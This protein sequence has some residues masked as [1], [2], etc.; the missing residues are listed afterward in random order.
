MHF[1]TLYPI[2]ELTTG[3]IHILDSFRVTAIVTTCG[4]MCWSNLHD[5][6][7]WS[8]ICWRTFMGVTLPC[9]VKVYLWVGL[10]DMWGQCRGLSECIAMIFCWVRMHGNH[11]C[12][13][14]CVCV[15]MCVCVCVCVCVCMSDACAHVFTFSF[16]VYIKQYRN[17]QNHSHLT[18]DIKFGEGL[19]Y[20]PGIVNMCWPD[21]GCNIWRGYVDLGS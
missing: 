10:A 19:L 11:V 6:V 9:T 5:I 1:P 16:S 4:D 8:G 7:L 12:V 14:V 15:C 18:P 2:A 13:C 21:T 3:I 17:G 20:R